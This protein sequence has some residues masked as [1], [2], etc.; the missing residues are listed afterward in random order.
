MRKGV[1]DDV[2]RRQLHAISAHVSGTSAAPGVETARLGESPCRIGAQSER[3]AECP[4]CVEACIMFA[5]L[6]PLGNV[7][8]VVACIRNA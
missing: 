5:L 1:R 2:K 6:H 4:T 3:T 7:S 8:G